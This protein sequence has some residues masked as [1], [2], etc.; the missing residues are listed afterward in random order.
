VWS[1]STTT[2]RLG[3]FQPAGNAGPCSLRAPPHPTANSLS[4]VLAHHPLIVEQILS[5]HNESR[6]DFLQDTDEWV[7]VLEGAAVV[8]VDGERLDLAP[9]DWV[10]LPAGV[11][12]SVVRTEIGT[13]WLAVHVGR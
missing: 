3:R 2:S 8:E 9:G 7:V 6:T 10:L 4:R 1:A 13:N 5:G 11:P 12:H